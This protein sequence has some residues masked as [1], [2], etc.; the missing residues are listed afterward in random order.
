MEPQVQAAPVEMKPSLR[1]QETIKTVEAHTSE[2]EGIGMMGVP[3]V[4]P[5]K[6]SIETSQ[7]IT[8]Q[9]EGKI[10]QLTTANNTISLTVMGRHQTAG[11][12]TGM[13]AG[14]FVKKMTEI[15]KTFILTSFE[16]VAI[17]F[18]SAEVLETPSHY[19]L[20]MGVSFKT[21]IGQSLVITPKNFSIGKFTGAGDSQLLPIEPDKVNVGALIYNLPKVNAGY[22]LQVPV[23]MFYE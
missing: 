12:G 11:L 13:E 20:I 2:G 6:S 4:Q 19:Q 23:D 1:F 21:L 15:R 3:V 17:Y 7:S 16:N 5:H 10:Y 14:R 9:G 8:T 22:T 18:H